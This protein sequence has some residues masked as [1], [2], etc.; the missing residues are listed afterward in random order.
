M[1]TTAI[2]ARGEVANHFFTYIG[3]M[4]DAS[5]PQPFTWPSRIAACLAAILL[6]ILAM[7]ARVD[8]SFGDNHL[9]LLTSQAILEH[10]SLRLDPY[11]ERC[12]LDSIISRGYGSYLVHD[13]HIYYYFP[14][15]TPLLSLPLTLVAK[16]T[17]ADMVRATD[18]QD[19]RRI[20]SA[21]SLVLLF[22]ILMATARLY[23]GP[24]GAV[25]AALLTVLGTTAASTMGTGNWS[26]NAATIIIAILIYALAFHT[27][28][29]V[30]PFRAG[31]IGALVFLAYLC[32]PS[33]IAWGLP[34]L[35]FAF[36]LSPVRMRWALISLGL[37]A[38][39]FVA[40][41]RL[42]YGLWLPPY[43][44]PQRLT[45][46]AEFSDAF[47]G[48]WISPARGILCFSP[49]ICLGLFAVWLPE[50]RRQR[51]VWLLVTGFLLQWILISRFPHWWGGWSFGPRLQT[52]SIPGLVLLTLIAGLAV[53]RRMTVKAGRIALASV[54]A[55]LAGWG[56][57]VHTYEGMYRQEVMSWNGTIDTA[58]AHYIWEWRYPQFLAAFQPKDITSAR[59]N[60][61]LRL[62]TQL[63]DVPPGSQ[64]YCPGDPGEFPMLRKVCREFNDDQ[65]LGDVF[66][67]PDFHLRNPDRPLYAT[68][69]GRKQLQKDHPELKANP[70]RVY[71]DL[72]S[73]LAARAGSGIT[74]LLANSITPAS[75]SDASLSYLSRAGL[76][77][78]CE[79]KRL[80]LMAKFHRGKVIWAEWSS[81]ATLRKEE[82]IGDNQV[83]MDISPQNPQRNPY[84]QFKTKTHTDF[85]A[86][87]YLIHITE[88]GQISSLRMELY[89]A[90]SEAEAT[91]RMK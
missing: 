56:V 16:M 66:L 53:W 60:Y 78:P 35:G 34:I 68:L 5:D 7:T 18:V 28:K 46:D 70:P 19:W 90:D 43:Y 47:W 29:G 87:S 42:E 76:A 79:P 20:Y 59:S 61:R 49:L 75:L 27:R 36:L 1:L 41:S 13:Q 23:I 9:S 50:M 73:A 32:R 65:T 40:W 82:Y 67:F 88:D 10:G 31:W 48:N 81:N 4:L 12:G 77:I 39:T 91:F 74:Y 86:S 80:G 57:L 26:H 30:F 52:E 63:R 2:Q 89:Q 21:L 71:A 51:L 84:F 38:I 83:I 45:A 64:L 15:G 72:G 54:T 17:G 3:P 58:P 22:W 33:A 55:L 44:A 62:A 14:V 8:N 24:P 69:S 37:L 11:V 25:L 85:S 6:V